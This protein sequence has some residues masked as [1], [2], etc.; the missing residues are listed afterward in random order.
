MS[1]DEKERFATECKWVYKL[2]KQTDLNKMESGDTESDAD[3]RRATKQDVAKVRKE[4]CEM[5]SSLDRMEKENG[6][7]RKENGE[8]RKE[9]GEMK[10]S[11]DRMEKENGE[12]RKENGEMKSSLDRMEKENKVALDRIISLVSSTRTS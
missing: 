8:M 9:S 5:K 7:M 3:G 10:S 6:E 12:M 1:E 11:L 4:N 2:F